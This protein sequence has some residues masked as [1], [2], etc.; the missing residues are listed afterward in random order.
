MN[1]VVYEK[2]MEHA[3]KSQVSTC[4]SLLFLMLLLLCLSIRLFM[5]W[6]KA[7]QTVVIVL[8]FVVIAVIYQLILGADLRAL[9]QGD[10][11]DREGHSRSVPREGY[12]GRVY[13]GGQR[14]HGDSQERGRAGEQCSLHSAL[15]LVGQRL[16]RE[17]FAK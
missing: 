7:L 10:C 9:A 1:E 4:F 5:P 16:T 3:G 6:N 14:I 13:E 15:S 12:A 8:M 11:E 2:V 17:S